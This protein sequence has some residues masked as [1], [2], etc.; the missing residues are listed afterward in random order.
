MKQAAVEYVLRQLGVSQMKAS[1]NQ[2][3][4]ACPLAPWTHA[5]GQDRNPSMGVTLGSGMSMV[6]CFACK[7]SG[8]LL[9]L[10][11]EIGKHRIADGSWTRENVE[12][13]QA[14]IMLR[15][16]EDDELHIE[17]KDILPVPEFLI[18]G[19]GLYHPYFAKRNISPE[20]A[21]LWRLGYYDFAEGGRVLFP[22]IARD[23]EVI[24]IQA[25]RVDDSLGIPKYKNF[26]PGVKKSRY[27]YG[28]HLLRNKQTV[29]I[30]VESQAGTVKAN[31]ILK[32]REEF[33]VG[34]M[35]SNP[36]QEQVDKLVAWGDEVVVFLDNDPAGIKGGQTL[37]DMLKERVYTTIVKY[38]PGTDGYDPDDLGEEGFLSCLNNRVSVV[39]AEL[40]K[41]L[42]SWLAPQE[43]RLKFEVTL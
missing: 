15:E 37:V 30:A 32:T 9:S 28:E 3:M 42:K 41:R 27:L 38:P 34:L 21:A 1:G 8:G 19:L 11:R 10:V 31:Q 22:I 13:L 39:E 17:E 33:A 23:G 18:D 24:G 16:E 40:H 36:S 4:I 12:Q 26:P 20:T 2:L 29:L 5:S 25:R 6:N 35:G 43:E 14:Y 7:F